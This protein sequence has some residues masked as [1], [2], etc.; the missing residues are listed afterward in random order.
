MNIVSA[1]S[2]LGESAV[3]ANVGTTSVTLVTAAANESVKINTLKACNVAASSRELTVALYDGTTSYRVAKGVAVGTATT[4]DV[5]SKTLYLEEGFSV[6][7][8]ANSAA[9]FDVVCSYERI[10]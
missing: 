3:A 2:V 8:S 4:L 7:V 1:A 9:S 5:I 6:V 10:S